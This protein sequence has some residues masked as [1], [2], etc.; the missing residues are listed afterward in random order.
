VAGLLKV[1]LRAALVLVLVDLGLA[2]VEVEQQI[3]AAVVA[4]AAGVVPQVAAPVC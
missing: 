4:A 3:R 2:M 1:V